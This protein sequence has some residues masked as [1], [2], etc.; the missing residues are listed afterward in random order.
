MLCCR[1]NTYKVQAIDS[2]RAKMTPFPAVELSAKAKGAAT[3]RSVVSETVPVSD[4][5]LIE[6]NRG[7]AGAM[8]EYMYYLRTK[9]IQ[10]LATRNLKEAQVG[11]WVGK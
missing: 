3:T 8:N 7:K 1:R 6:K 5:A 2:G 11:R 9:C 10:W 4:L